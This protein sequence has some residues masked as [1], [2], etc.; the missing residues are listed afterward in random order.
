MSLLQDVRFALRL[1]RR[2]PG[3]TLT[4]VLTLGLGVGAATAIFSVVHAVL[5]SPLP[6]ADGERVVVAQ[7]GAS[8]EIA[9][10]LSYPQ[11]VAWRDAGVLRDTGAFFN[12]QASLTGEGDAEEVQGLRVSASLFD[13][14]GVRPLIGSLFTREDESRN[15]DRKVLIGEGLWRRR[16]GGAT[17][18]LGRRLTLNDQPFTIVGVLPRSFRV[19]PSDS[20]PEV[21][22]SLRLNEQVAPASLHFITGMGRLNPGQTVEQAQAALQSLERRLNPDRQPAPTVTVT[23][24]RDLFAGGSRQVL[25]TLLAAVAFLLL[26]S[27][28][29]LANLLLARA[30]GR[31]QEIAVRLALGAGR[32]RVVQ[33]LL[34]ESLTLA[35][36]GGLLGVLVAWL[37]VTLAADSTVVRAAGAYA[38]H[39]NL[40]VLTFALLVSIVA[41]VLFGLAPALDASRQSLRAGIGDR[42]RVAAGHPKMRAALIVSEVAL[43]LVLLVGAG[44]LAR[45]FSNLLAVDKGFDSDRILSFGVSTP[46]ARYPT[47]AVKTQFFRTVLDRLATT[48]G[49]I[50]VGLVSALPL[51]GDGTNGT[52]TIEGRT[53][54]PDQVPMPE[55]R[56]ASPAYFHTLGIRVIQGRMFTDRDDDRAPAVMVVSESFAKRYFPKGDAIGARAGFNWDMDGL[57]QIIGVVSDVKQYELSE[58][59]TQMVYVSYLQRPIDS[60]MVVMKTAGEPA[61]LATT[62]REVVRAIDKD[63]PVTGL[64]TLDAIVRQ[65]V[66]TRRFI[67]LLVGGFA[68]IGLVLAATGIYGVVNYSVRQRSREFGIRVALGAEPGV[69]LRMV[70][71]QGLVVTA[72]GLVVGCGAALAV[73]GILRHQLFGVE[74]TDALTFVSVSAALLVVALTAS[75]LPARRAV[76]IDPA[77]VLRAE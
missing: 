9:T 17:T 31:R 65:S 26:I 20:P 8:R 71:R 67:L 66:A 21:V 64:E 28:A 13:A 76:K 30:A 52:V 36:A 74:P 61:A 14:L 51:G 50:K 1:L 42:A 59:K 27:C 58:E 4:A 37:G 2:M 69:V 3:F 12:W 38:V 40:P 5:F 75:Y 35:C 63:R 41:G 39:V 43:T 44:L 6:F 77:T 45:S 72:I 23:S 33:Q 60:A 34:T 25:L 73:G 46:E 56:I 24:L 70:L 68:W 16:F 15:A 55:K 32:R 53:F 48:P 57:Q 19:R 22:G 10:P 18:V 7:N 62:T 29:N 11:F 47:A 49:A 54:A